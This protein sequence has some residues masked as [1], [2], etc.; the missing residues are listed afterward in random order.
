[1]EDYNEPDR[2]VLDYILDLC[3]S[4]K[5]IGMMA[6]IL[7]DK[8]FREN[9][10]F[11]YERCASVI[12]DKL[13]KEGHEIYANNIYSKILSSDD[14]EEMYMNLELLVSYHK[15]SMT[16]EV[17][18]DE[19]EE[20][21]EDVFEEPLEEQEIIIPKKKRKIENMFDHVLSFL[22]NKCDILEDIFEL[23]KNLFEFEPEEDEKDPSSESIAKIIS[24]LH[25]TDEKLV[26]TSPEKYTQIAGDVQGGKSFVIKS[27]AYL[28][29]LLSHYEMNTIKN[30]TE[31][32]VV[33]VL[34]NVWADYNQLKI[35]IEDFNEELNSQL[36]V[37]YEMETIYMGDIESIK[38]GIRNKELERSLS[39]KKN[40]KVIIS[41]CNENQL[42]KLNNYLFDGVNL[43]NYVVI[44]D[45]VD[46][47]KYSNENNGY[48]DELNTLVDR[49]KH[50]FGV[51][52]T[53][54]EPF[55]HEKDLKGHHVFQIKKAP[56]YKSINHVKFVPLLHKCKIPSTKKI[57]QIESDPN[58]I[59]YYEYI[60]SK[61]PYGDHP[62][63][64]LHKTT[65]IVEQHYKTM[66]ILMKYFPNFAVIV[67][68]GDGITLYHHSLKKTTIVTPDSRKTAKRK[69][70]IH[71]FTKV[72]IQSVLQYLKENGGANSFPHIVIIA[73]IYAGRSINFVSR[74]FKWHLTNQYLLTA[75]T[76]R[77]AEII[78]SMR[79]L[80]CYNDDIPLECHT[81]PKNINIIKKSYNLHGDFIHK[82]K[83]NLVK[84][85]VMDYLTNSP[86]FEK[87]LPP[88]VKRLCKNSFEITTTKN[89]EEDT[90]MTFNEFVGRDGKSTGEI[91]E[92]WEDSFFVL[93][94][95]L[96]PSLL[97][98]YNI[99]LDFMRSNYKNCWVR[100]AVLVK[101]YAE[102]MNEQESSIK[103]Y[104]TLILTKYDQVYYEPNK[105]KN[106]IIWKKTN[107]TGREE[108]M[109]HLV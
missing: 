101:W 16:E 35:G 103:H 10:L 92:E 77:Y 100:R 17:S 88:N 81:T 32:N 72:G 39:T 13:S 74:D 68:D 96:S 85:T 50:V 58:I 52:A 48:M 57:N 9:P 14:E 44:I 40:K 24:G 5:D 89:E 26:L 91:P 59:P 12:C 43:H 54:F 23:L 29:G 79:V 47:L 51:S 108:Y 65:N 83:K 86:I 98:K 2:E 28:F 78:Q 76:T 6:K 27:I 64:S 37:D 25:E 56:N 60:Q 90:G 84:E 15:D 41:I 107:V 20:I 106:G 105:Y 38:K 30:V 31:M 11:R 61:S 46:T 69:D 1:M 87:K 3:Q 22:N 102:N 97:A 93:E 45:E 21:F 66:E 95:N 94:E 7:V 109:L 33:I 8:K 53:C 62:I 42:N 71:Y 49:S 70:G 19:E 99:L 67:Y 63:I 34:R 18:D 55:F 75:N 4:D 82:L 36:D 80:G 104:L 73:G